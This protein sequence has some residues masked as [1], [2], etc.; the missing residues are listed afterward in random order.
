MLNPVQIKPKSSGGLFGK[1]LGAAAPIAG[2]A[3]GSVIPGVG[4][5]AGMAAGG[6]LGGAASMLAPQGSVSGGRGVALSQVAQNDPQVT[7]QQFRDAQ[8]QL[9]ESTLFHPEEKKQLHDILEQ[10][11]RFTLPSYD[12]R[13]A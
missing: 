9:A 13:S 11:K 5:A 3:I 8:K 6:A 1:I 12:T 2:A 4:T 10:G 7:F